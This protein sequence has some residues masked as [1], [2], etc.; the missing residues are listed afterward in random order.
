M[1]PRTELKRIREI[2]WKISAKRGRIVY[3]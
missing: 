1:I 2:S 3:G